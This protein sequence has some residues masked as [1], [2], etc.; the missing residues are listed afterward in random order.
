MEKRIM[1]DPIITARDADL[2]SAGIGSI[3]YSEINKIV[4]GRLRGRWYMSIFRG[5]KE[6]QFYF[7]DNEISEILILLDCIERTN[8]GCLIDYGELKSSK[9]ADIAK[10]IAHAKEAEEN[11]IKDKINKTNIE[12]NDYLSKYPLVYSLTGCRGRSIEVY[13]DRVVINTSVTVGSVLTNNVTDGEKII[14]YKDVVGIQYKEP[15]ITI[16][17]IQLETASGQMNNAASNQF[18]EN[19]FTFEKETNVART[20]K[21]YITMQVANYKNK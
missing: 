7:T 20:I 19:T 3:K 21:K 11:L 16:G 13:T 15:G 5:N 14:Y 2:L 1:C 18:S 17:Y 8:R 10:E 12:Y 9:E 6:T 4:V